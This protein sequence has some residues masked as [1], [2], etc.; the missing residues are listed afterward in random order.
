L[1]APL[2]IGFTGAARKIKTQLLIFL[3]RI[4]NAEKSAVH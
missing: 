4:M 1:P 3:S 2:F